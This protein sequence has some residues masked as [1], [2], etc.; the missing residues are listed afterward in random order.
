[1]LYLL[2]VVK[3]CLYFEEQKLSWMGDLSGLSFVHECLTFIFLYFP[4]N[5]HDDPVLTRAKQTWPVVRRSLFSRSQTKYCIGDVFFFFYP[6]FA[7]LN[8]QINTLFIAFCVFLLGQI[9]CVFHYF[10]LHF[11]KTG[12]PVDLKLI[13]IE[14]R[15][16]LLHDF[17]SHQP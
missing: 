5:V 9:S 2:R 10:S 11:K 8:M 16:P 14:V 3:C 6:S 15:K 4:K 7:T 1:M 17:C 12:I 13:W